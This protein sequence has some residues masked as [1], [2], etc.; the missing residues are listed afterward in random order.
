MEFTT[1]QPSPVKRK[2]FSAIASVDETERELEPPPTKIKRAYNRKAQA[3][4]IEGKAAADGTIE[5]A[6]N[7]KQTISN[8]KGKFIKQIA[9]RVGTD[10]SSTGG[11]SFGL[12]KWADFYGYR[13][14][15]NAVEA[16]DQDSRVHKCSVCF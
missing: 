4:I 1:E 3:N 11:E 13:E 6:K 16:R 2:L 8:I 7:A 10:N 9:E 14:R 15:W 5:C 12:D